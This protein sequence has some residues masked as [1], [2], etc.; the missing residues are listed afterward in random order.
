MIIWWQKLAKWRLRRFGTFREAM[1][2]ASAATTRRGDRL[3]GETVPLGETV[4]P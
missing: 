4:R 3:A 1:K 2:P